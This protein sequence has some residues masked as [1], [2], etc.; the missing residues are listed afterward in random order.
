MQFLIGGLKK[1][2]LLDYPDKISAIVFTQGCNFRCG[3]CHNPGLLSKNS[4][5]VRIETSSFFE[6]LDKRKGKLDAVVITGGEPTLQKDLRT[7]I[8]KIKDK[9]FLVK[10]DTNGC[11]P[12]IIAGLIN[13]SLIDYI[14]MDIKAPFEKYSE[15][16]NVGIDISKI[17][18]SIKIIMN[19]QIEYEFRTTVIASQLSSFDFEQIAKS[20]NGA[21]RYYLQRFIA[22]TPISDESLRNHKT[23][24]DKEFM[25]I[26]DIIKPYIQY[27]ELR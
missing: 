8:T 2:S 22:N 18:E 3:Y 27:I 20:I 5:N 6:F 14:A 25:Q 11:S 24:S 26:I 4:E 17:K 19:S 21:K 12:D 7:F 16:V 1:T 23:Y 15:V 13:D 10:L 9:G